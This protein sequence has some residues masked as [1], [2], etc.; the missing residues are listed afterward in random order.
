MIL[1]PF[2][3]Q[4]WLDG[5][6]QFDGQNILVL[7][8][9]FTVFGLPDSYLDV[10]CGT[11]IMVKT[12]LD[13]GIYAVGVDRIHQDDKPYLIE[14]D[15]NKA[16]DLG[17]QF[18][19]VT[20]LEVAEHIER[21]ATEKYCDI[22]AQHVEPGGLLVMTAAPPGQPGDGHINCQPAEFWRAKM[23]LRGLSYSAAS[24]HRLALAWMITYHSM[25]WL[26]ANL[27]VFQK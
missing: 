21:N 2:E 11:G 5:L 6:T 12:A 3:N 4:R 20:S 13:L 1:P 23:H 9:T 26:E 8:A 24:T 18:R 27:Q 22:L 25:H 14:H 7:L 10:G 16:L 19:L 17:R 15:L